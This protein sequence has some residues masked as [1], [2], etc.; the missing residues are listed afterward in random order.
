MKNK[1]CIINIKL[2]KLKIKLKNTIFIIKIKKYNLIIN[3]N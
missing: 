1:K 3:Y 2:K